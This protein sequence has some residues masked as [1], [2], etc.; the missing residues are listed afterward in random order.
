MPR[1]EAVSWIIVF[2]QPALTEQY[3]ESGTGFQ[4]AIGSATTYSTKEAS[5]VDAVT[6]K[7][8]FGPGARIVIKDLVSGKEFA[9]PV[10]SASPYL[11]TINL[12]PSAPAVPN[13][14]TVQM[15][16]VGVWSDGTSNS[17]TNSAT[18]SSATPAHVTVSQTGLLTW[19]AA[20]TSV[21]TCS[22]SGATASVTAT[23]GS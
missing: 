17:I 12:N 5:L 6:Q 18:W 10:L 14:G 9:A 19:V 22:Q 2:R 13:G 1:G 23:A 8:L 11:N 4:T 16:A 15:S 7:E 21:I 20:G 3:F